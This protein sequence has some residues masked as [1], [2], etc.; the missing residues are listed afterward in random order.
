MDIFYM[1]Q[2][3]LWSNF[4]AS[5][6]CKQ[7]V[8][9]NYAETTELEQTFLLEQHDDICSVEVAQVRFTSVKG[10]E[11]PLDTR[12]NNKRMAKAR[13]YAILAASYA[14]TRKAT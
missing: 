1:H 3:A 7:T 10:G 9:F 5:S 12:P 4:E 13:I 6:I 2:Q 14:V 8:S 11:K